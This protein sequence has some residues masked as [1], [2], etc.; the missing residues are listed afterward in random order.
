MADVFLDGM[1]NVNEELNKMQRAFA[2]GPFNALPLTGGTLTGSLTTPLLLTDK[3]GNYTGPVVLS[4]GAGQVRPDGDGTHTMGTGNFRWSVIYASSGTIAT[5]DANEKDAFRP[6]SEAEV[7]VAKALAGIIGM[8]KWREAIARKG[9]DARWHAGPYAQQVI[10]V[11]SA[12]GLDAFEHGV[13]CYD[14][15]PDGA[16]EHPATPD[17]AAWTEI[18]PAGS[19][20]ALRYDELNLWLAM[21]FDA[22][23]AALEAAA[24]T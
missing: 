16:I 21:G 7:A 13:A 17:R 4:S 15:W 23:L 6:F 14:E 11:F 1:P 5:S 8:Y 22:R 2:A 10:A 19:R 12:H 3:L 20:Y 18:T 24:K 9:E